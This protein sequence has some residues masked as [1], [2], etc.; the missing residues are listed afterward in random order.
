MDGKFYFQ[1]SALMVSCC[2]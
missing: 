1:F 2:K